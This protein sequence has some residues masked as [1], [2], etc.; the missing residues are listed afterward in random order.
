[1]EKIIY[2]IQACTYVQVGRNQIPNFPYAFECCWGKCE[3]TFN[4]S[5]VFFHH[6][7]A[8]VSRKPRGKVAGGV[9]C[10]W[11]GE[12]CCPYYDLLR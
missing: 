7:Q 5:Q 10:G 4:N 3:R 8:H 2:L 6:I 11:R 1:M 12:F 9:R